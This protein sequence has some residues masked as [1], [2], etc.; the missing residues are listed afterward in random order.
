MEGNEQEIEKL[1]HELEIV[2]KES[3]EPIEQVVKNL[4]QHALE[5]YDHTIEINGAHFPIHEKVFDLIVMISKE[6]DTYKEAIES[7][8]G[9]A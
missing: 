2:S 1:Q 3:G 5:I 8:G 4:L 9:E 7:I 6:R